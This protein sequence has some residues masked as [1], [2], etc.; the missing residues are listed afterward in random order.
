MTSR[1]QG[2][3]NLYSKV[4]RGTRFT[5]D[6]PKAVAEAGPDAAPERRFQLEGAIENMRIAFAALVPA[7]C[8]FA[9]S[10]AE[11]KTLVFCSEGNPESLNPQIATTTTGINAGRPVLQQSG[12][13]SAGLDRHRSPALAEILGDLRRRPANTSSIFATA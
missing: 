1:L 6:I 7:R 12:G 5:I 9:A 2:H 3:I 4:G 10:T 11:A 8:A 13:V